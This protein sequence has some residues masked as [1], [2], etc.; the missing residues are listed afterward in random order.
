MTFKYASLALVALAFGFSSCDKNDSES[1]PALR[2]KLDASTL[3]SSSKYTESFKDANGQSTVDLTTANQR[4]DMFS[5]LNSYMSL[6]AVAAP[7]TPQTL[8]VVKLRGYYANTGGYFTGAGLN[9]S[10]LQLRNTT[11]ASFPANNAETVRTYIDTKLAQ[12]ATAS[13]SVN[14]V[15]TPGNAGRLGRYLVDANG[16]EVN[17]IIQK[18]LL[19]ALLLDQIDNVLLTDNALSANN[20][21]VVDGKTYSELE[22]NWDLAYGYLTSNAI[23]TTDINATPRERF[24]AGYLNEKNGPASPGVYLAFLKGRASIVNNDAAGVKTQAGII[25]T[26]LEKTIALAAV[27]YLTNWKAASALDVK[28]HALGEGIGFIYSLRFCSKYG[29]DA[30][31]SDNILNGLTSGA[32]GAWSLTNAQADVAINA[33]KAKFNI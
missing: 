16:F 31:F 26:E 1:A 25:R 19:G 12:L 2:T 30:A 15:A 8:D 14:N 23:M 17:Q 11:A 27:S 10:G 13:Q 3:T 20:S 4:L 18:A 22:H 9:S 33:I 5:E 7:A 29:A 28:A 6:V 32:Q 24:L 21:K